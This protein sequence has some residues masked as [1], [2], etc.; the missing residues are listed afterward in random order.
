[1]NVG[2]NE[3]GTGHQ[4][5]VLDHDVPDYYLLGR[6]RKELKCSHSL[7]LRVMGSEGPEQHYLIRD[8][9]IPNCHLLWAK[10]QGLYYYC[11]QDIISPFIIMEIVMAKEDT[12]QDLIFT[13]NR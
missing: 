3:W 5:E 7:Q 12:E 6:W 1:M 11:Q 9:E 2:W 8:T 10:V 4:S 13:S